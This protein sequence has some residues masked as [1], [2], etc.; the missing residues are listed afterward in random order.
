MKFF[1]GKAGEEQ[2]KHPRQ[3]EC[4]CHREYNHCIANNEYGYIL[5]INPTTDI[6][7]LNIS[8]FF[9]KLTKP[10]TIVTTTVTTTTQAAELEKALGFEVCRLSFFTKFKN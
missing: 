10:R 5:E 9:I 7:A 4:L 8:E 2:K 3:K 6:F 1:E